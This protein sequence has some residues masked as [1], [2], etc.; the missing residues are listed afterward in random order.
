MMEKA[1]LLCVQCDF[2]PTYF[3]LSFGAALFERFALPEYQRWV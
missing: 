2:E 3:G 1:W